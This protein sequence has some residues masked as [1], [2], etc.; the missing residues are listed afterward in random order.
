MSPTIT[1]PVSAAS[2]HATA[3][4]API[5]SQAGWLAWCYP[6]LLAIIV[7]R[8]WVLPFRDGFWLDETGTI[9]SIEAGFK[10]IMAR[11]M[12][13]PSQ[14]PAYA[15]IAW[16]M[17][18]IGGPN[19]VLL[20][21]PSFLAIAVA[22]YLIYRLADRLVAP[23]AG[24]PAA[25]V[26]ASIGSVSFAASDARPYAIA[27]LSTVAATF[28]LVRWLDSGKISDSFLY[29]LAAAISAYMHPLFAT[30][31][32]A[33][34]IYASY[35]AGTEKRVSL[36]QLCL[37]GGLVI[38]LLLPFTIYM[39]AVMKTAHSHSFVGTPAPYDVF[40]LL[41][42]P[43]LVG[44]V[45]GALLLGTLTG[46]RV[47]VA[48][49]AIDPSSLL[50]FAS[51]ALVPA[52]LLYAVSVTT[53]VKVFLPRYALPCEIGVAL[54]AGWLLAGIISSR[55][56]AAVVGAVVLATLFCAPGTHFLHGGDWRAAMKSV[57]ATVSGSDAPVLVRSDFPE[58]EPFDWLDNEARKSYIFA[59]LQV[60]PSVA[61]VV[62]LP[63]NLTPD[64]SQYLN[65]VVP[66]LEQSNRFILVNMGDTSYQN[67]LQG[68]LSGE[69]F[70]RRRIGWFGGSL[71]ADL[72]AR[73]NRSNQPGPSSH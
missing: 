58:S 62:P 16:L 67:W 28:L 47:A 4:S 21:L 54:F 57:N 66:R 48:L 8:F 29:C 32:L 61:P 52:A 1:S 50:L 9:W 3:E 49:P 56:R 60:Y 71:T 40:A 33:Q 64:V 68:R 73:D 34:L 31:L 20:R 13:W 23:E 53:S 24:W 46:K 19:T 39:L 14:T 59:P 43:V 26:F 17:Y 65:R 69:G 63:M 35:R 6:G 12:L 5:S 42:P 41:A 36:G 22:T 37:A 15:A 51:T 70:E 7:A 2:V 72:Y 44:G 10:N 27:T 25:I 55:S 38:L 18:K 45:L 11:C 30:A